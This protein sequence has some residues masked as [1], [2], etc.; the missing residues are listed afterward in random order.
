MGADH[1]R[2]RAA[3]PE[4]D[5]AG[6]KLKE[7]SGRKVEVFCGNEGEL[8]CF[9]DS[10][11]GFGERLCGLEESLFDFEEQVFDFKESLFGL[12]E[13]VF[14]FEESV[15]GLEESAFGLV[16]SLHI[17]VDLLPRNLQ[18]PYCQILRA[19]GEEGLPQPAPWSAA[20]SKAQEALGPEQPC[21]HAK[22]APWS[23]VRLSGL[24]V[25]QKIPGR[26]RLSDAS[27]A[28]KTPLLLGKQAAF[29]QGRRAMDFLLVGWL[30]HKAQ[31]L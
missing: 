25:P 3:L 18:A 23:A 29:R 24:V 21:R 28:A 1:G 6:L 12:E 16:E 30:M 11:S 19:I 7:C 8:S 20:R 2:I 13:S 31:S 5:V 14:A 15:F 26:G 17:F 27:M 9:S 22:P 10:L 4:A